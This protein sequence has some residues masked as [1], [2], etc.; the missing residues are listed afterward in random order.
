M[1]IVRGNQGALYFYK[2]DTQDEAEI[3]MVRSWTLSIEKEVLD[4]TSQGATFRSF[5][6]SL[7]TA[8]GTAEVLYNKPTASSADRDFIIGAVTET[9]NATATFKLMMEDGDS[10]DKEITFSGLI[11]G[12]DYSATV[13]EVEV[14]TVNFSVSGAITVTN[15]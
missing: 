12:S 13:S 5:V 3:E 7:I 6:G 10:T 4:A 9:D 11:T 8:T 14:I 2:D 15:L 1:A